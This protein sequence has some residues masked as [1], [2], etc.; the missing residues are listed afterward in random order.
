MINTD[1]LAVA[2]M[3]ADEKDPETVKAVSALMVYAGIG[4]DEW[5]AYHRKAIKIAR[6]MRAPPETK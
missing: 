6:I 1:K 4:P 5:D 2:M 3:I